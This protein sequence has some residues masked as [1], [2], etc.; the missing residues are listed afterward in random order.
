MRIERLTM[1]RM[2]IQFKISFKHAAAER[3]KTAS[4]W[5]EAV[6]SNG[7]ITG[8]GEGCPRDYVTGENL[9][10]ALHWFNHHQISIVE[11]VSNI[12]TLKQWIVS[13][14]DD[15]DRNPAAWC[16]IELA[17]LDLFGKMEGRSIDDL[18]SLPQV[19]GEFQYSAVLG[20]S[21]PADFERQVLHY[22]R[23]EF[24]DYKIKLS[25]KCE[26]DL[27]KI[28]C[29]RKSTQ[30]LRIRS[31]ANNLWSKPEEVISY[32]KVLGQPFWAIEEPLS[33]R[34]FSGLV[35]IASSLKVKIIL[36][37]S[38]T[39]AWDFSFC[40]DNPG[41]WIINF[42]ISK[43]GGL[44]RSLTLLSQARVYGF[45]VIIGAHVG[46]T[47]ILTRA[48][49]SLASAATDIRVAMEGAFGTHLLTYDP[50]DPT[51]MFGEKGILHT[52]TFPVLHAPGNGLH[53]K[54]A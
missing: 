31:D 22:F 47:S 21:S 49:L 34:N 18:L 54:Q 3:S 38:F 30:P 12:E 35:E 15:I 14:N 50:C 13:H 45:Q 5:V 20:D 32:L 7:E 48:A 36:D 11:D 10:S 28:S 44:I 1:T 52:K 26:I 4:V 2:E 6:S 27:E 16:A 23:A 9:N 51:I 24:S 46:E 41:L 43:L 8:Y 40:A 39:T 33:A 25:G 29:L 17:L 19:A 42:R 53:I 37:E